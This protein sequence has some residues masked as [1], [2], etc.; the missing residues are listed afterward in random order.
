MPLFSHNIYDNVR[1][2]VIVLHRGCILLHPPE[3][4]GGPWGMPGGGLEPNESLADCA[5]REVLEETGIPVQVGQIAFIREWVVPCYSPALEPGDGH[6]YGLEVLHYAV[7]EEPVPDAIPERPGIPAARWVPLPEVP[8]LPLW[9]KELK[10]LCLRLAEGR[11]PEGCQSFVC[12]LES[13]WARCEEDP[14]E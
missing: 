5:R 7:P 11:A 10:D 12:Q 1:T 9:P 13:P 8:G 2:R 3:Q 4:E 6:G 14:F